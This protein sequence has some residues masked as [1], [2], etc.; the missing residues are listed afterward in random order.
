MTNDAD[1]GPEVSETFALLQT[2]L[3]SLEEMRQFLQELTELAAHLLQ[4]PVSVGVTV[5][6]D[7]HPLTVSSSDAWAR[8]LDETQYAVHDGPCLEAMRSGTAVHVADVSQESRWPAYATQA[9][10]E[11]LHSSLSLPLIVGG[12]SVGAVNFYSNDP[13]QTFAGEVRTRADLFAAQASGALLLAVRQLQQTQTTSQ[14]ETALSSRSV[15]DQAIGILM[16][17][18]NCSPQAGFDLLRRHS[19][20][21]NRPL[22]EIAADLV[23][24]HSGTT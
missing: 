13:S 2:L 19:Q 14:L 18:Q 22:R 15:I 10:D 20:N 4:P 11:G 6:Y 5:E 21:N 3:V 7:G 23:G 8:R 24:R 16:A 12:R 17:Q 9:V 1:G